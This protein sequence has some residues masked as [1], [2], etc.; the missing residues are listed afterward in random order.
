MRPR[1]RRAVRRRRRGRRGRQRAVAD[2]AAARDVSG[3]LAAGKERHRHIKDLEETLQSARVSS[4]E[5]TDFGTILKLIEMKQGIGASILK[6]LIREKEAL[7]LEYGVAVEEIQGHQAASADDDD[8]VGAAGAGAEH[9]CNEVRLFLQRCEHFK[10]L[11]HVVAS[12]LSVKSSAQHKLLRGV[13]RLERERDALRAELDAKARA[14]DELQ[15]AYDELINPE[16]KASLQSRQRMKLEEQ[17]FTIRRVTSQCEEFQRENDR[18]L[19]ENGRL[20]DLVSSLEVAL[21][22]LKTRAER[23]MDFLGPRVHETEARTESLALLVEQL[24][25]DMDLMT[26]LV[27][28]YNVDMRALGAENSRHG[29]IQA[30]SLSALARQQERV[31]E[32]E[33]KLLKREKLTRVAMTARREAHD[34]ARETTA[35]LAALEREHDGVVQAL[36]S[37]NGEAGAA[38]KAIDELKQGKQAVEVRARAFTPAA[39]SQPPVTAQSA[40][41]SRP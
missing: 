27:K 24:M 33:K 35:K 29:A 3:R 16:L 37:R 12:L 34:G 21:A 32:L 26:G 1:A 4:E 13:E 36:V 30:E 5:R 31:V 10:V 41:A 39:L 25:L 18:L 28:K 2:G 19:V 9:C 17:E 40:R 7:D 38:Q 15:R 23:E 6:A 8:G 20:T 22:E 14:T 11:R